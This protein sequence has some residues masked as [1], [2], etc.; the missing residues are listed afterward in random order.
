[1][2]CNKIE[3]KLT[4]QIRTKQTKERAQ[5]KGQ[6]PRYSRRDS[7]SY[8]QQSHKN[9]NLEAVIYTQ[10]TFRREEDVYKIKKKMKLKCKQ[11][12]KTKHKSYPCKDAIEV[13]V[14][15]FVF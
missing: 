3:Q 1:M 4:Y 5:E 2:K 11:T 10:R 12:S 9:T 8:T 14:F 7:H 15:V 6:N 13:F